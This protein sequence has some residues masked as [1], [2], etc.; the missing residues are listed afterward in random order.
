LL[1][2]SCIL[3]LTRTIGAIGLVTMKNL[4]EEG[5]DVTGFDRND[6][7]GGLWHYDER[8]RISVLESKLSTRLQ[9]HL[10]QN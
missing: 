2:E 10:Q 8:A 7:L 3:N 4:L 1:E 6:Y 9:Q 5:F